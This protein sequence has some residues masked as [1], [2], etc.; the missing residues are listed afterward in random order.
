MAYDNAQEIEECAK[1]GDL[2]RAKIRAVHVSVVFFFFLF[3]FEIELFAL[4]FL[5]SLHLVASWCFVLLLI[6]LYIFF[7]ELHRSTATSARS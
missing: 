7:V 4:S 5:C 2:I 3:C 6:S 1:R